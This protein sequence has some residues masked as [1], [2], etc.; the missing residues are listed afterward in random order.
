MKVISQLYLNLDGLITIGDFRVKQQDNKNKSKILFNL[1]VPSYNPLNDSKNEGKYRKR[2]VKD[3]SRTNTFFYK[4]DY[5]TN[6]R[7]FK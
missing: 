4:H 2:Y 7:I 5:K 1:K 6:V 3:K